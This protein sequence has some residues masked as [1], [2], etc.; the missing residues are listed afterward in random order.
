MMEQALA[1]KLQTTWFVGSFTTRLAS[2]LFAAISSIPKVS[3]Y[4][5]NRDLAKSLLRS[6][7]VAR[8]CML[9]NSARILT[10]TVIFKLARQ[11]SINEA[12]QRFRRLI[13][14]LSSAATELEATAR[15]LTEN[16]E[17]TTRL[18]NVVANAS[19]DASG[20]VSSVAS[21]TEQLSSC[22]QEISQKIHHSDRIA[23]DA[24]QEAS[25]TDAIIS[26]L[27]QAA[28]KIGDVVKLITSI[29][30]QT[31]LLALNATIEAA[32]AG[33]AGRGFAVVAQ[34][35]KALAAQ[36][37]KATDE[38]GVQIGGMQSATGEAVNSI[39]AIGTTIGRISEI[40][41]A[42]SAAIAQQGA[43]TGEIAHSIQ[44]AATA[45]NEVAGTIANMNSKAGQ[46]GVT[47]A[48]LLAS[49]KRLSLDTNDLQREI[50]AFLIGL[51]AAA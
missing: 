22:I 24:V 31:S 43:A 21:A 12:G 10:A 27:S 45:T 14:S 16:A 3:R 11:S 49:A 35:V 25:E 50:D 28:G 20:N 30:E 23:T 47:S 32:R 48:E 36:T 33:E 17:N 7:A 51:A 29:A 41:T 26:T 19:N 18:A 37:A 46:T 1:A 39:K 34:E 15:S 40:T 2:E 38:I 8:V 13:G 42:I 4:G 44:R 5:G 9:D 6:Q